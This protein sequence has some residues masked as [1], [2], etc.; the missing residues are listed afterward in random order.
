MHKLSVLLSPGISKLRCLFNNYFINYDEI[1][2][3]TI[4]TSSEQNQFNVLIEKLRYLNI[5]IQTSFCSR[6]EILLDLPFLANVVIA[7][8]HTVAGFPAL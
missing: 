7:P 8:M 3:S 6:Q 1:F 4:V 5:D 2:S